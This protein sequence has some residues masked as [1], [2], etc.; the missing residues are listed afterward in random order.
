WGEV[1]FLSP[2]RRIRFPTPASRAQPVELPRLEPAVLA[3]IAGEAPR[4]TVHEI[5]YQFEIAPPVGAGGAD[6]LGF[7]QPIDPAQRR[8]AAQLVAHELVGRLHA[9]RLQRGLEYGVQQVERRIALKVAGEEREALLE[10]SQG[11]IGLEQPLRDEREEG[12]VLRLDPL[13][14]L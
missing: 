7:E 3:A 4:V 5:S 2:A 14:V 1:E 8:A 10:L 6:D 13:P 11:A 12:R 9:F